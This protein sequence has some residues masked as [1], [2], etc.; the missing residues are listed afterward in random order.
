VPATRLSPELM[1]AEEREDRAVELERDIAREWLRF[2]VTEALL[3]F[4]PFVTFLALVLYWHFRRIRPRQEEIE[5]LR[6]GSSG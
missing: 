6:G 4:I 3:I 1:S 5:A 2:S